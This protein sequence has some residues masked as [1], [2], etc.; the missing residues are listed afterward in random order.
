VA[1]NPARRCSTT[2]GQIFSSSFEAAALIEEER[3]TP[4]EFFSAH[5][6]YGDED[7]GGLF[8]LPLPGVEAIQPA[9]SSQRHQPADLPGPAGAA[10][11]WQTPCC[12]R[13]AVMSRL[14][15]GAWPLGQ[16]L[17]TLRPSTN[18]VRQAAGTCSIETLLERLL[19][20][21]GP[22]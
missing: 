3:L 1:P 22:G 20:P 4:E 10:P 17:G 21:A 2:A 19:P 7:S 11:G 14:R 8:A 9:R 15:A 16:R 5:T 13:P 18:L 12:P 6:A